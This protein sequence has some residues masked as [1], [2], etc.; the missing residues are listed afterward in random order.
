MKIV[1]FFAG[2]S[3]RKL[4]TGFRKWQFLLT[5]YQYINHHHA[6]TVGGSVKVPKPAYVI[7]EW[8]LRYAIL[9]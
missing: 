9:L 4:S 5:T 3:L 7:Y 2:Q 6:Y 8:S 1:T